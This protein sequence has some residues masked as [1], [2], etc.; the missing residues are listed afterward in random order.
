MYIR[1]D[2][3]EWLLLFMRE[4][5]NKGKECIKIT[6]SKTGK[7]RRHLLELKGSAL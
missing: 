7:K 6:F 3:Q 1:A 2:K 5:P 4:V